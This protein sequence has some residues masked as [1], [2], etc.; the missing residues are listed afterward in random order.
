[1]TSTVDIYQSIHWRWVKTSGNMMWLQTPKGTCAFGQGNDVTAHRCQQMVKLK[2]NA[3]THRTGSW[4]A[5]PNMGVVMGKYLS[6]SE[7]GM[8]W[9]L[10]PWCGVLQPIWRGTLTTSRGWFHTLV[11]WNESMT[12]TKT[13]IYKKQNYPTTRAWGHAHWK[14]GG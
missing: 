14:R 5:R 9:H 10:P 1:M 12:T 2:I 4:L 6:M 13:Q 8:N 3:T 11:M 7:R